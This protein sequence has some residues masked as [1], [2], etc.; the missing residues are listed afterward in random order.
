MPPGRAGAANI[1]VAPNGAD[2]T[3]VPPESGGGFTYECEG[4]AEWTTCLA[5]PSCGASLWLAAVD[6][7]AAAGLL[8]LCIVLPPAPGVFSAEAERRLRHRIGVVQDTQP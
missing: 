2:F 6:V 5:D 3:P 7:E 4:Y 8:T 1:S